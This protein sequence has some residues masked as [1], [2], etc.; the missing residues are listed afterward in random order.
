MT[1][2]GAHKSNESLCLVFR[3]TINCSHQYQKM[4]I[5]ATTCAYTLWTFA[6]LLAVKNS[7]HYHMVALVT[8]ALSEIQMLKIF[9]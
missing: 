6:D 3:A 9:T 5:S 7:C 8:I 4:L 2:Q 1:P